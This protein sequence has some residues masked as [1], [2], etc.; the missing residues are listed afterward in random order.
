MMKRL[1]LLATATLGTLCITASVALIVPL[2]I[3]HSGSQVD[4]VKSDLSSLESAIKLFRLDCG[5]YPSNVEG[6]AALRTCPTG[7]KGKWH[8]PYMDHAM[9]QDPWKYAYVY[10]N[11]AHHGMDSYIVES[12]GSDGKPGGAGE[13]ADIIGGSD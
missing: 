13:A 3:R 11:P 2:L 5:R 8:G 1:R 6:L 12:Y 9:P 7:L 4:P 10:K